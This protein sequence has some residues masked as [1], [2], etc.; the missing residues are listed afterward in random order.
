MFVNI[1]VLSQIYLVELLKY[2]IDYSVYN[3]EINILNYHIN[4]I[5]SMP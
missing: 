3:A 4:F 1:P 2:Q 5:M